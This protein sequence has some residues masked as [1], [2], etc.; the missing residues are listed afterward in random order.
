[1]KLLLLTSEYPP[2][3]GG[4]GAYT[5]ELAAAATA[6]GHEVVVLAPDYRANQADLDAKAAYRTVRFPGGP[7]SAQGLMRRVAETWRMLR[8]EQFDVIHA[9][10]WPFFIP[11]RLTGMLQPRARRLLT[12]HGTEVIYMQSPKRKHLLDLIGFWRQGWATWIGNSHYTVDLLLKTFPAI[13]AQHARAV[14]LGVSEAWSSARV[15]RAEARSALGV[16]DDEIIMVSLGRVV[17]RKGH[18]VIA[19]ALAGLPEDTARRLRWWVIGPLLEEGYA[20]QLK[21]ATASLVTQT[22]FLGNLPEAEVRLRLSA[23]DLFC[24]PGYKDEGGRVEG[25]GLVFLEAAAYG[26]PSIATRSGGIPEAVEDWRTGLLVAERDPAALAQAILRL[27]Q[28]APL[29]R[30]L[31]QGAKAKAQAATWQSVMQQTYRE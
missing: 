8:R 22:I 16:D 9:V 10:D 26:V 1:V 12:V 13:G 24:L 19:E 23:A 2:Y 14:P 29:R 3:R 6:D 7:A 28:D 31:G 11:V 17:P 5:R 21:S 18:G 4:I 30:Q 15:A 20:A 27:C 25:F